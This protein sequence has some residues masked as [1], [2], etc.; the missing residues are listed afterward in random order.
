MDS[1]QFAQLVTACLAPRPASQL[2]NR[3]N[4]WTRQ[5]RPAIIQGLADLSALLTAAGASFTCSNTS[6]VST[7]VTI[8]GATA[9]QPVLSYVLQADG[10]VLVQIAAGAT[11]TQQLGLIEPLAIDAE[12]VRADLAVWLQRLAALGALS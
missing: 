6:G 3:T 8:A 7:T 9:G 1:P 10:M 12:R 2:T 11:Q 5:A 4:G